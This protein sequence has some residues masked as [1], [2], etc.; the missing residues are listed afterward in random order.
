[1]EKR[2]V[3]FDNAATTALEPMVVEK[4][5][6]VMLSNFGNPSSTH[7]FGRSSKALLE[8]ARKNI[9]KWLHCSAQEIVFTS[10]GTEGDNW[11]VQAA[12]ETLEIERIITTKV[13]HHAVLY[14]I[15][16]RAAKQRDLEIVYLSINREGNID[17]EELAQI[18]AVPK[19]TLVSL[20]HVNNET[21]VEIDV[22]KVGFLC[23]KYQAFFHSDTVQSMGK[24]TYDLEK[25]KV[26][27]LVGS[28]HKFH[29]PKGVGFVFVRKNTPFASFLKGGAQEKGWRAGTEPVHQIV[30]MSEAL[31]IAYQ[32]LDEN[33]KHITALK[34]ATIT[35]L[36]AAFP[37]VLFNGG[38][39]TF[40]TI[41]NVLLPFDEKLTSMILFNLDM[42][43]IAVSRGSACQSGSAKPSHVLAEMLPEPLQKLPSIRISF[44]KENT[45]EEVD[46]LV[47]VLKSLKV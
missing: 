38:T 22:E 11:I 34:N 31:S 37:N 26:H 7:Q 28:A 23:E 17:F 42:K 43:G 46:Y 3:Y 15:Q 41:L 19:K 20:M 24:M 27:F 2:N 47:E 10:G 9:A 12:V 35:K 1:M 45:F 44:S 30:G 40:Y 4:M 16:E 32:Q 18:L 6:S 14:P 29:G 33:K 13:E 8:A 21:G 36:Q 5:T 39:T 25:L